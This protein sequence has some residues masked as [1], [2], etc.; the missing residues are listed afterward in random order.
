M[1]KYKLLENVHESII[2]LE[3]GETYTTKEQYSYFHY[4]CDDVNDVG[5]GCGYRTLQSMCSM[6]INKFNKS[7]MEVPSVR[8]IQEIL[9]KIGDKEKNF[10]NS[11]D[12]IGAL[13]C[14]YVLDELFGVSSRILHI[15]SNDTIRQNKDKIVEYFKSQGGLIFL[16]GDVDAAAKLITGVHV[17]NNNGKVLLQIVDPHYSKVPQNADVLINQSYVKWYDADEDFI[18]GSFYNLC[19]PIIKE[20]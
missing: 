2:N 15:T 14:S 13:E 1:A 5:Y 6:I 12:W 9:V 7:G 10:I 16:G 20:L 3:N 19:M 8:Q 11:R 17:S 4:N 18:A